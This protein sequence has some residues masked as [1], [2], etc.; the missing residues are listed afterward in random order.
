MAPKY[1]LSDSESEAES[2]APAIPSEK[3]LEQGL[4]NEVAAVF[5]SGN[6]EGLT[7]K[8][9]R[10]AAEKKL[11]LAEGFFK[12]E[13]DWKAKSEQIIKDEVVRTLRPIELDVQTQ[14]LICETGHYRRHKTM[15]RRMPKLG[16]PKKP[17]LL[18]RS[19]RRHQPRSDLKARVR[20]SRE[21]ARRH[22]RQSQKM[23]K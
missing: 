10:L 16:Q 12:T 14:V 23:K 22:R 19:P 17:L 13:G 5:K 11:G 21:N 1:R 4:R 2:N 18:H 7:V 3:A 8:R 9:V 6:M 15:P 20:R